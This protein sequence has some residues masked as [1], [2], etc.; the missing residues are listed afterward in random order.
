MHTDRPI[1]VAASRAALHIAL[2]TAPALLASAAHAAALTYPQALATAQAAA[3]SLEAR[4]LQAQ[5]ARATARAAGRLPDPKVGLAVEGFPISGPNAGRP[6]RDDFSDVRLGFSQDIPSGA[7]RQAQ[8]DRAQ[9]DI[10]VADAARGLESRDV[11]MGTALAWINLYYAEQRLSAL[12][13]LLTSLEP[14]WK[15]VP[16]SV[17][18][19]DARPA[20]ALEAGQMRAELEDRRDELQAAAGRARA[21]LARWT[22][23]PE[24]EITGPPPSFEV[25]PRLLRATIEHV[26][27][28]AVR[29][30]ATS[31]ANAEVDLA[32][33]DKRPDWSWDV[34]YQ[35]RDPRFG[36]M[37]SVGVTMSLPIFGTNR[38]DPLIAARVAAAGQARAEREATRRDLVSQLD[39]GV[40]DHVM[41]HGQW[42][43]ARDILVP[44]AK[45]RADLETA[46]YGAGRASLSDVMQAFTALA[47]AQLTLLDREAAVAVDGARLV[48]TFG[49]N[50]Q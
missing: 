42:A 46:S 35:R 25:D 34:G 39:A 7:K 27:D 48:L 11:R 9:S 5:S 3:P 31:Q 37:V 24:A 44:L 15:G 49:S 2:I 30:A 23:E 1:A 4:S 38:Q 33:A 12:D 36:D 22:G 40:A 50:D 16:S 43:R 6:R 41:H 47:N 21:E 8:R 20:Q 19:G 28:L 29:D 17:A 13:S 32:R 45:Q 14:L 26:P 18:S 10:T